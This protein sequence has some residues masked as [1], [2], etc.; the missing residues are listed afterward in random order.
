MNFDD[1]VKAHSDWKMKLTKY[2]N[3]PDHSLKPAEVRVD[4]RCT[5]GQ[6]I[7]G[8]GTKHAALPEFSKLRSEHQRFHKAAAAVISKADSGVDETAEVAL[9]SKSEY[10]AASSGV[11]SAIM[12]MKARAGRSFGSGTPHVA[13]PF[14]G[15]GSR[16]ACELQTL[17][18][19]AR[20][21]HPSALL[22]LE[23]GL[24]SHTGF[25]VA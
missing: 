21:N 1:A 23:R 5:L 3:H 19:A 13:G 22:H 15:I 20:L 8:E 10:A 24:N 17:S 11:V 7:Y 14:S 18:A 25:P 16:C 2:I 9:G 4:N 12:A 6:W